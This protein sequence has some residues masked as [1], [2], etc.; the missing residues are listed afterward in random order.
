[1]SRAVM[2]TLQQV[3]WPPAEQAASGP[4][5]TAPRVDVAAKLRGL[6]T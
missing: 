5:K 2:Q 3:A 6:W 4:A 1:M